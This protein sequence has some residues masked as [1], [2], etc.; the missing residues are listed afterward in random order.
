MEWV[1]VAVVDMAEFVA[2]VALVVMVVL[3]LDLLFIAVVVADLDWLYGIR[4]FSSL[5]EVS[6][7]G[8]G[9]GGGISELDIVDVALGEVKDDLMFECKFCHESVLP[10]L[11]LVNERN[12]EYEIALTYLAFV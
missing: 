9:G 10:T 2:V 6:S 12:G 11:Q 8:G 3:G 5:S 4:A 7:G 1:V